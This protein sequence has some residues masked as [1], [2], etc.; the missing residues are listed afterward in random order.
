MATLAHLGVVGMSSLN[1]SKKGKEE[2]KKGHK[3][4]EAS[5][6]RILI[7][8]RGLLSDIQKSLSAESFAAKV[9]VDDIVHEALELL[10]NSK[11]SLLKLQIK[12]MSIDDEER[13]T[14]KIYQEQNGEIT[15]EE[16]KK[17]MRRGEMAKLMKSLGL[18]V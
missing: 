9:S 7:P 1:S 11:D 3:N 15:W 8:T 6:I 5:S 4:P 2:M 14:Y 10:R 13:Y 17:K 16:F 18:D 12:N